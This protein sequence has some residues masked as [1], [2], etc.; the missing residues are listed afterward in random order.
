MNFMIQAYFTVEGLTVYLE[1]L[2][3]NVFM[4]PHQFAF[5]VLFFLEIPYPIL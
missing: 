1:S 3:N 2:N 5:F 4:S